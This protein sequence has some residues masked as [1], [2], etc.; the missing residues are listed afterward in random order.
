MKTL[1]VI[2]IAASLFLIVLTSPPYSRPDTASLSK[3]H[4]LYWVNPDGARGAVTSTTAQHSPQRHGHVWVNP[5]GVH[6]REDLHPADSS[7]GA[8]SWMNPD[9]STGHLGAVH[10]NVSRSDTAF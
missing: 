4:R 6:G 8:Y 5:E 10:A 3:D 9:G 1:S 7:A 2:A